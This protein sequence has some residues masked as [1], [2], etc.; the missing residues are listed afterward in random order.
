M[1]EL[2][3]HYAATIFTASTVQKQCL[4]RVTR[5]AD[6]TVDEG[7]MDHDVDF[8]DVMSELLKN[9]ASWLPFGCSSGPRPRRRS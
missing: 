3:A 8:R 7:M 4:F 5:N 6:I 1:E 2:I 9:A